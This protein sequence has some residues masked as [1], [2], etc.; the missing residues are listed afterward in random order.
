MTK[1]EIRARDKHY[2]AVMKAFGDLPLG[3]RLAFADE[4]KALGWTVGESNGL[5]YP[6]RYIIADLAGVKTVSESVDHILDLAGLN[7]IA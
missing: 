2:K 7:A 6:M 4:A 5:T 1:R 3:T